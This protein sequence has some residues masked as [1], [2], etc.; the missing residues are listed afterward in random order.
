M[1]FLNSNREDVGLFLMV[2]SIPCHG[3]SGYY[4]ML[5]I[6]TTTRLPSEMRSVTVP[7][8]AQHGSYTSGPGYLVCWLS[9]RVT[10]CTLITTSDL[11]VQIIRLSVCSMMMTTRM[12]MMIG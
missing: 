11:T 7:L 8:T 4:P 12:M 10:A 3:Q 9:M 1:K 2:R 6:W 5:A